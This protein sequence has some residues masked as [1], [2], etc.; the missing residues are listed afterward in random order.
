MRH[1]LQLAI[2]C[3]LTLMFGACAGRQAR[4]Q[5][6]PI[7]TKSGVMP[8]DVAPE[9]TV[10]APSDIAT[11][12]DL[13][14][15]N[16]SPVPLEVEA[17]VVSPVPIELLASVKK[18]AVQK[19]TPRPTRPVHTSPTVVRDTA[20]RSRVHAANPQL[21]PDLQVEHLD[22]K[23]SLVTQPA[24]PSI[25]PPPRERP[26]N[27]ALAGINLSKDRSVTQRHNS[28]AQPL[29]Q[30]TPPNRG[31]NGPSPNVLIG[32]LLIIIV[33][34]VAIALD[35]R[36]KIRDNNLYNQIQL[37]DMMSD[38]PP[39]EPIPLAQPASDPVHPVVPTNAQPAPDPVQPVN[40]TVNNIGSQNPVAGEINTPNT[41]SIDFQDHTVKP[42]TR[43]VLALRARPP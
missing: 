35:L 7:P 28:N 1:T 43:P 4:V 30:Q 37:A 17:L 27:L 10:I 3:V 41:P 12:L 2:L 26:Q 31:R 34:L 23:D 6:M 39:M 5:T 38:L 16:E 40:D 29:S 33:A 14:T 42:S 36:G 21:Q 11:S 13:P 18:Q 24:A 8:A 22:S 20:S 9:A 19:I 25:Y 32:F 15:P